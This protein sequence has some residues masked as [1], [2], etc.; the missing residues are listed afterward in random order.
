MRSARIALSALFLTYLAF[1]SYAQEGTPPAIKTET[2]TNASPYVKGDQTLS[3]NLGGFIPISF[4][5]LYAGGG[6][7]TNCSVG[8]SFGLSYSYVVAQNFS[9]GGEVSGATCST[10]ADSSF[11]MVPFT[12]KFAWYFVKLPFEIVPSVSPGLT[13]IRYNT[14]TQF[15]PIIKAG[16]AFLWRQSSNWSFGLDMQA[17]TVW[18]FYADDPTNNRLGIF[19]DA[20]LVAVYHL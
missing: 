18:N 9:V 5:D 19:L 2:N 10:T 4:I 15:S 6:S 17:W 7:T 3:F 8:A 11:F 20:R 14:Y 12:A 16:S 13:I 1:S